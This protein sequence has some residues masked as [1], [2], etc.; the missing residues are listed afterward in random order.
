MR[1]DWLLITIG[2][3][4]IL[5]YYFYQSLKQ[6]FP[7]RFGKIFFWTTSIFW[8][9]I[10]L[11][12]LS[13]TFRLSV[14][15]FRMFVI[16]MFFTILVP[17]I[18]LAIVLIIEDVFRLS[19]FLLRKLTPTLGHH[20]SHENY[21]PGRRKFITQSGLLIAS[22]PFSGILYG[23]NRGKYNFKIHQHE[24]AFPDLPEEF[25]GFRMTQVSDFHIGS[26]TDSD[27][28]RHGFD[29]I[30]NLESDIIV[31][32]GDMVNN[33]AVEMDPWMKW[34][35]E[36]K[37]PYGK[38]SILGNHDYGDYVRWE[39]EE[40]K[41]R[42]LEQLK[43]NHYDTG[44]DL[45]LNS[46]REIKFKKSSITLVGVE[47]WG[48]PPF[49]QKGNLKKAL[50][51]TTGNQ[52]KILLSHDPTHW[53]EEIVKSSTHIPLTLSGHTHGMQFGVEIPGFKWSPVQY[54]YPKWAGLYTEEESSKSR[55]LYVNRGFGFI[56]LPGR[57]GIWPEITQITLRKSV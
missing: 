42:N 22:I 2:V 11:G 15:G 6:I 54:R 13:F 29:M 26:F 35:E 5:E 39:S 45:L 30:Q 19:K 1:Y 57:V 55:F 12:I 9:L 38:F 7:N 14:M 51:G 37:A 52:F 34:I 4:I 25:D 16:G 27:E 50:E 36:L 43:S 28:V 46:N 23:V 33:R 10:I 56:G 47:N 53:D 17:K 8:G 49:P 18:P 21:I 31:F 44:F 20:A 40:A 24:F 48:Q 32:T 41:I 3:F